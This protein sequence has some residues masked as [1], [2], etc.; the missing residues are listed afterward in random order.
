M[1]FDFDTP[2]RLTGTHSS[3]WD[4]VDEM[5]G[6]TADDTIPMWIADMDFRAP[7]PVLATLQ[8]EVDR[9]V[10]GYFGP[11][12]DVTQKVADWW[13]DRHGWAVDPSW[14]TFT[15]G[16][17]AGLGA[18]L[19]AFTEPGDGVI[20]FS[21]VYHAF[22]RKVRQMG[23]EI[24]ESPLVLN[25]GRYDMDLDALAASLTGS[26]KMVILCSPHNP[27][28]RMWDANELRSLAEFCA[29]HDMILVSDEIHM[30]LTFPGHDHIPT[31]VAAPD[32]LPRLVVLSAA[33]KTFNLAGGE[34][35]YAIVADPELRK[36]FAQ[37]ALSCGGVTNR[38]GLLMTKAA[39]TDGV[40]WL[41]AVR[42]YIAGNFEIFKARVD[43]IPGLAAMDMP[44]TYLTWVDFAGT[45]MTQ[46]EITGRILNDAR[47]GPSPGKQ[48]GAGGELYNRFNIAMPRPLMI[49][50]MERLEAAFSDLQ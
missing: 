30:D 6:T 18:T 21:P 14:V 3:K 42:S 16:V 39:Y 31:A 7:P 17:V 38:F 46:D 23:R 24:V 50:A 49:E 37:S 12:R 9:G 4:F 2:V 13:T 36:T 25:E 26:E 11:P 35:G 15:T 32:C 20:V 40:P 29:A 48:F 45:G 5:I 41:D 8:A 1:D 22:F 34:T 44:S 10:L 28:G 19:D 27:G 33:S 47:I 43:A